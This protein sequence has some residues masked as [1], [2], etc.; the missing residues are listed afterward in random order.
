[1]I[2]DYGW[3][4]AICA[5]NDVVDKMCVTHNAKVNKMWQYCKCS[6]GGR[7]QRRDRGWRHYPQCRLLRSLR[8][9]PQSVLG[10]TQRS[11]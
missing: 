6:R 8:S 4:T 1:M 7:L 5:P 2:L 3:Q 9:L 11:A 10:D